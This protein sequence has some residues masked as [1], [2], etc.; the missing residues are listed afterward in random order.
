MGELNNMAAMFLMLL[1]V[2]SIAK[3]QTEIVFDIMSYG[4]KHDKDITLVIIPGEM[5]E[6]YD[7]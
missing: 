7:D 2:S 6:Y 4:G 3:A 5:N 1:F